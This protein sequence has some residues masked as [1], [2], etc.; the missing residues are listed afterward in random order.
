MADPKDGDGGQEPGSGSPGAGDSITVNIDGEDKQFTPAELTTAIN[1]TGALEKTVSNLSGFQKVLTRYGIGA[2]EY[3]QNS[4]SAL[5]LANAL[6]E[7]GVI[8][9]QGN[10]IE[11][12]PDSGTPPVK[13]IIPGVPDT[14]VAKKIGTIEK[15]LLA[16]GSKMET[17][18][19][20]QSSLYRRNVA[21]DVRDAHP[22]LDDSDVSK[23]LATASADKSKD[24]WEHAEA[25]S[26]AKAAT[27]ATQ[28]NAIAKTTIETLVKAGIIKADAV[29]MDKFDLNT[30]QEQDP[31][32]G[33]PVYEGKKFMFGS[34]MRRL[35]KKAKGF[36]APSESMKEMLDQKLD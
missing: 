27:V 26:K 23:L 11:K 20:G 13:S 4:E 5:A 19:E 18:Q 8:D 15:A 17:I 32:G 31:S 36:V 6:I 16:L 2:E 34:R 1:K 29:D 28:T 14:G 3:L 7:K 10:I 24:F 25:A 22:N 33:A 9:Q 30:L 21:A 12:K 35:G